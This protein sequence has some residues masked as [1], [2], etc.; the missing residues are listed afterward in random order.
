[1]QRKRRD[2][3]IRDKNGIVRVVHFRKVENGDWAGDRNCGI[4]QGN[5]WRKEMVGRSEFQEEN[6]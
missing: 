1:M 4:L 6:S 3:K 2:N 5:S